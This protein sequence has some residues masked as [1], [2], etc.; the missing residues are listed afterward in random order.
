MYDCNRVL[1]VMLENVNWSGRRESRMADPMAP[2]RIMTCG[3]D[4]DIDD[5]E[6]D[7]DKSGT[8]LFASTF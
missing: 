3:G 1:G 2:N 5:D 8:D 7:R 4:D 6:C